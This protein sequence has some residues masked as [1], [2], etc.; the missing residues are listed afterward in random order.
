MLAKKSV[1]GE[2]TNDLTIQE[3]DVLQ[4]EIHTFLNQ[5][6]DWT[7]GY[8]GM[9]RHKDGQFIIDT[10]A[11]ATVFKKGDNG[12]FYM[13]SDGWYAFINDVEGLKEF[14]KAEELI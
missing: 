13:G 3:E 4:K 11:M 14:M 9:H 8:I 6:E 12:K 1:Y 10:N 5:S 7:E 2:S